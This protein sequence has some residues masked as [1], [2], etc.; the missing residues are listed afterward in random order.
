[1]TIEYRY[2]IFLGIVYREEKRAPKGT[3]LKYMPPGK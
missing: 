3:P 1:M 2:I